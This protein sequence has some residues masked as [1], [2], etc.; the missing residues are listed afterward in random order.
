M[1]Y[2]SL[3]AAC[4]LTAMHANAVNC[5]IDP[6]TKKVV[7]K[8]VASI[9]R[10]L[11]WKDPVTNIVQ[12]RSQGEEVVTAG[13]TAHCN[14]PDMLANREAVG[15]VVD[16][17]TPFVIGPD[18]MK[19][20]E[21]KGQ[22]ATSS[23][24]L[25]ASVLSTPDAHPV[26]TSGLKDKTEANP[27]RQPAPLKSD[28]V[29]V[30]PPSTV[31]ATPPTS[32]TAVS[33]SAITQSVKPQPES[34]IAV[35]AAQA[36]PMVKTWEILPQDIS[37]YSAMKRWSQEAGWQLSWEIPIDYPVTISGSVKGDFE[38]AIDQV[39]ASYEDADYPPKGCLYSNKVVRVVR[40]VG[41]GNEC[42]K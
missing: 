38:Q 25:T 9:D 30:K 8:E 5:V 13:G 6:V 34:P 14:S 21:Y 26:K 29:N 10:P 20:V 31:Q 12:W 24:A 28:V 2:V 15:A 3:F 23:A 17:K 7:G 36:T 4:A 39:F 27:V 11:A 18:G 32:P 35:K 22:L 19:R 40:R 33:P 1:K 16:D 42:T 41:D 37:I